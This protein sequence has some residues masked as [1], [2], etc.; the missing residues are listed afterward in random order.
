MWEIGPFPL[1][2]YAFAHDMTA[3]DTAWAIVE[4]KLSLDP[5]DWL[6]PDEHREEAG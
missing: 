1:R 4:G 2:A 5:A 6:D 3:A